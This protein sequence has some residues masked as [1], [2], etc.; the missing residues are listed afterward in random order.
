MAE[1]DRIAGRWGR[2]VDAWVGLSAPGLLVAILTLGAW[3][4]LLVATFMVC[5][6]AV[7][8]TLISHAC[9]QRD[10]LRHVG[11]LN[12]GTRIVLLGVGMLMSLAV[13][14]AFNP[15]IAILFAL[16]AGV[17]TPPAM[18]NC[19]RLLFRRLI[20][21]ARRAGDA[22]LPTSLLISGNQQIDPRATVRDKSSAELRIAWRHSLW[23][24]RETP[25]PHQKLAV[26]QLRQMLLD[27]LELRYARTLVEALDPDVGPSGSRTG[28]AWPSEGKVDPGAPHGGRTDNPAQ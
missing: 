1:S 25:D 21:L 26:V 2:W 27:E 4:T 13:I 7:T 18:R 3:Q 20:H 28:T 6:A 10:G 8:F 12:W 11:L 22:K 17:S 24:L 5:P 14:G 19:D 16:T 15:I 9:A 23:A